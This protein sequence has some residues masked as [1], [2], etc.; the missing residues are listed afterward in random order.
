MTSYQ[1]ARCTSLWWWA[2]YTRIFWTFSESAGLAA[3]FS[4]PLWQVHGVEYW[5][6]PPMWLHTLQTV[7]SDRFG[8]SHPKDWLTDGQYRRQHL[9]LQLQ[10]APWHCASNDATNDFTTNGSSGVLEKTTT[11]MIRRM[12]MRVFV[13]QFVIS[14]WNYMYIWLVMDML[15]CKRIYYS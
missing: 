1:A 5:G 15:S 3:R 11:W 2:R 14:P 8:H 12:I 13:S 7:P 6:N 9:A 4:A 10:G